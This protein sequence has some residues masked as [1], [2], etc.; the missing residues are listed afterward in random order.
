MRGF[1]D[2]LIAKL[3]AIEDVK[4]D[5]N[6]FVCDLC[7]MEALLSRQQEVIK[8]F[9]EVG[10]VSGSVSFLPFVGEH[11]LR[12]AGSRTKFVRRYHNG[13]FNGDS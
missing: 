9:F 11:E 2:D 7:N 8:F 3:L 5:Q 12:G 4:F 6:P 10:R 13:I 1:D